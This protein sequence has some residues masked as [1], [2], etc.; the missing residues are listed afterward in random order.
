MRILCWPMAVMLGIMGL[1][2]LGLMVEVAGTL[3]REVIIT[4]GQVMFN[5]PAYLARLEITQ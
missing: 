4:L 3:G 2:A 1:M 5:S